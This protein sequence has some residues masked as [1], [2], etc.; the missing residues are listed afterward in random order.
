[1][2]RLRDG[3]TVT[4]GWDDLGRLDAVH[5]TGASTTRLVTDAGGAPIAMGDTPVLWDSLAGP[6]HARRLG[7]QWVTP[8]TQAPERSLSIP[9]RHQAA[10]FV[11]SAS[12]VSMIA[13]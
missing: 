2:D 12:S 13:G 5:R 3:R 4:Y 11:G 9:V 1:M 6:G 8:E 7:D 10:W